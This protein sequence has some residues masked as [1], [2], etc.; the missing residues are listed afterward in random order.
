MTQSRTRIL[1]AE[2]HDINQELM[3][4]MMRKLNVDGVVADDG[5][6]AIAMVEMS[7]EMG[8]AFNLV[9]M[10]M[11]MPHV[12]GIEATRRL[13]A[14]G[15]TPEILPIVAL[16]ANAFAQDIQAC[17]AAGMQH[18]LSKP[19]RLDDLASVIEKFATVMPAEGRSNPVIEPFFPSLVIS[20]AVT[21]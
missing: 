10:D 14:A 9:L 20:Q 16:T 6:K 17:L 7:V 11:Q 13:R 5:A 21:G 3:M 18:H 1:L 8:N 2:D 4:A 19:I 15:F 12:D